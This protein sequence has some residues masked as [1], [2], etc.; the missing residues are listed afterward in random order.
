MKYKVK[1]TYSR[2]II[3]KATFQYLIKA[4][5]W[6]YY[7][8]M[9]L[10]ASLALYM[11]LTGDRTILLAAFSAV[12]IFGVL[13]FLRM[14]SHYF[15]GPNNEIKKMEK[16]SIWLTI[17]ENG[18]SFNNETD[19]VKWKDLY[20]VWWTEEAY[21]FFTAKDAFII[22]PKEGFEDEVIQFINQKVNK[23]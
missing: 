22:C 11:Y 3:A 2:K 21:L 7:V 23:S 16:N 15:S 6:P 13:I 10:S 8:A 18:I 9:F 12:S 19:S 20:K 14:F 4:M 17:R 1:V 5:G